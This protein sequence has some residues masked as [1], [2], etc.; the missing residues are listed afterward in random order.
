MNNKR[1]L[2]LSGF[3]LMFSM[4]ISTC[5][6]VPAYAME[7]EGTE[8]SPYLI[9][10][11]EDLYAIPDNFGY[12][13][14]MNDLDLENIPREPIRSLDNR[15]LDGNGHTIS[16]ININGQGL[17]AEMFQSE[18]K[19]LT[20]K[21]V[22][23]SSKEK[24][25]A[26]SGSAMIV[27]FINCIVEDAVITS[28]GSTA[29][30]LV[31]AIS[32][33]SSVTNCHVKGGNISTTGGNAGGLAGSFSSSE[34]DY[35]DVIMTQCSAEAIVTGGI[36]GGLIGTSFKSTVNQCYAVSEIKTEK[37]AGGLI[38]SGDS[39]NL[40]VTDCYSFSDITLGTDAIA[41]GIVDT[42]IIDKCYSVSSVNQTGT[43]GL[44]DSDWCGNSY[45]DSTVLGYG[46][47]DGRSRTT[48]QMYQ[49]SNY[50]YWDFDNI[51]EIDD[52]RDYP[53]LQFTKYP[54]DPDKPV[55]KLAYLLLEF[56]EELTYTVSDGSL[57]GREMT[58]SSSAPEI[59]AVDQKGLIKA[60]SSGTAIITAQSA[61][62]SYTE[63]ITVKVNEADQ[64]FVLEMAVGQIS[65]LSPVKG[66]NFTGKWQVK[67]PSVVTITQDGKVTAVAP[68]L[69][70][71]I[72]R[73]ADGSNS[74][75]IF[76]KVN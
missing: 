51:W 52:G 44:S 36:A 6:I 22:T 26:L 4:I 12:F 18:V 13:K 20:L 34:D 15:H 3:I 25:G 35:K 31:A 71:I 39:I 48:E 49:K 42:G 27:D 7:G 61:G 59:A 50:M 32:F 2:L 72:A 73:N 67:N 24:A 14:L 62:Q 41:S 76:I 56:G 8:E 30:G 29:G 46:T 40:L 60:V 43:T 63:K 54:K 47:S 23:V 28:E 9:Q 53:R 37:K 68:G 17:F 10:T 1:K 75:E 69:T 38:G 57:A 58:W 65:S 33:Y 11:V 55:I 5:N 70:K 21:H 64:Q 66:S 19:D 74:G 16:N 45:F